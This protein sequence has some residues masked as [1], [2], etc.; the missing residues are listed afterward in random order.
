[1]GLF[2]PQRAHWRN[3]GILVND[4]EMTRDQLQQDYDRFAR[5]P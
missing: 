2:G 5:E 4:G 3:R 1:M